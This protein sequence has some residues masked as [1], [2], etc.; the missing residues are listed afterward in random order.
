[1]VEDD[2]ARAGRA[3]IDKDLSHPS[4]F[5]QSSV[6]RRSFGEE[7]I[8][9]RGTAYT[10]CALGFKPAGGE[11]QTVG[12]LAHDLDLRG[13]LSVATSVEQLHVSDE[14]LLV[15]RRQDDE[16]VGHEIEELRVVRGDILECLCRIVVKVRTGASH[17]A[18]GR[19]LERVHVL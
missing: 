7:G 8:I 1:M 10:A 3:L 14:I 12:L 6:V 16:S 13:M 17:T 4:D 9:Y 11:I 18:Q 5:R 19:D 2:G 15:L